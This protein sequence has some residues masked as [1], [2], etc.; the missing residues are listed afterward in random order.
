MVV[1]TMRPADRDVV[2]AIDR[3]AFVEE[4]TF[5]LRRRLENYPD[6]CLVLEREGVIAG[7]AMGRPAGSVTVVGPLVMR[8]ASAD[9]RPLLHGLAASGGTAELV[10]MVLESHARA[11]E[12]L[13]SLGFVPRPDPP[14]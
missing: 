1:R 7:Y 10:V 4:R 6:L 9:P 13:G 3:K 11:V 14:W 5:F 2:L 8:T 12:M